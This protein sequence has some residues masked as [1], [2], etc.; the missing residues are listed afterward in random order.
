MLVLDH[1]FFDAPV[2]QGHPVRHTNQFPVRKHGAGTLAPV[3]QNHVNTGS[4]QIS[5]QRIGCRLNL[6]KTVRAD[7]AQ[8]YRERCQRIGPDDAAL[9]VVLLN[10]CCRQAG[11]ADAVA[12]HFHVLG[13]AVNV[14]K[15]S[16]HGA[17]VFG[18]QVKNMA[19][20]NATL[21]RQH[22]TAIRGRVA[23]HDIARIRH[24]LRFG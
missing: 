10:G 20:L 12:A 3:I 11:D 24:H 15:S 23:S 6:R 4:Y 8:H 21:D 5:V 19:N 14:E 16:L 22:A 9:V 18:T 13:L 2:A 17:A 1:A 7:R